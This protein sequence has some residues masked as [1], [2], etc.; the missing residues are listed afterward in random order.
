MHI[1]RRTWTRKKCIQGVYSQKQTTSKTVRY[2]INLY[3]DN[4]KEINL[5]RLS[6]VGFIHG[7]Q[8][9]EKN[10]KHSVIPSVTWW[11]LDA[12]SRV[13]NNGYCFFSFRYVGI[14]A[15]KQLTLD[16]RECS[17]VWN[18]NRVRGHHPCPSPSRSFD[19]HIVGA[20]RE[21]HK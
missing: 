20:W 16:R 13:Q 2:V 17:L 19:V 8:N 3:H 12:E 18:V 10:D 9:F 14:G 7:K 4:P 15:R 11:H 6:P 1:A 21:K 5:I